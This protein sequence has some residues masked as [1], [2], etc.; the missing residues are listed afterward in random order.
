MNDI[1]YCPEYSAPHDIEKCE[2]SSLACQAREAGIPSINNSI[3]PDRTR[4][5]ML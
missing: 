2:Q 4:G 3:N 1:D 5:I